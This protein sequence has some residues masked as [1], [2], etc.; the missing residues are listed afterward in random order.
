M[1]PSSQ[2]L[3]D[4]VL[5]SLA[6]GDRPTAIA[7]RLGVRRVWVYQVRNWR[8]QTRSGAVWQLEAIGSPDWREWSR[9]C[10]RG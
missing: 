4:R 9:P 10:G 5:R 1:E 8:M 7:N 3:R 6:R 2:D